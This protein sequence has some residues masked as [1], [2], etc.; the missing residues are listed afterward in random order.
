LMDEVLSAAA[1]LNWR[2]VDFSGRAEAIRYFQA[3]A[4][5]YVN[6][7]AFAHIASYADAQDKKHLKSKNLHL[8]SVS[9]SND[10]NTIFIYVRKSDGAGKKGNCLTRAVIRQ[11]GMA[12]HDADNNVLT[13]KLKPNEM[14]HPHHKYPSNLTFYRY[15]TEASKARIDELA[16]QMWVSALRTPIMALRQNMIIRTKKQ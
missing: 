6:A 13:G 15:K 16:E 10:G 2:R 7:A 8:D 12:V 3:D 4:Q 14:P 1:I 11:G 5:F 9:V